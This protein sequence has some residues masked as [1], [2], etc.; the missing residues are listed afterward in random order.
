[1]KVFIIPIISFLPIHY[2]IYKNRG[3]DQIKES[4]LLIFLLYLVSVVVVAVFIKNIDAYQA[5]TLVFGGIL[6]LSMLFTIWYLTFIKKSF[7]GFFFIFIFLVPGIYDTINYKTEV[8]KDLISTIQYIKN[9][10]GN[11]ILY[12]PNNS[13]L[14]SVFHFNEKVY[15]GINQFILYNSKIDLMSI[16]AAIPTKDKKLKVL[17]CMIFI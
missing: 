14:N 10:R 8:K 5:F 15:T 11:R 3:K 12:L 9:N 13:E 1:M 17:L 4:L 6:T 7:W 16:A 2:L